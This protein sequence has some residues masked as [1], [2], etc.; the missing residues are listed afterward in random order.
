M[1]PDPSVAWLGQL[2]CVAR[3]IGAMVAPVATDAE[4]ELR[5]R[6]ARG[7][8][9]VNDENG[10]RYLSAVARMVGVDRT[11]VTRWRDGSTT[12][13]VDHCRSLARRYPDHFDE[14]RLVELHAL[15]AVAA[16]PLAS[17]P[18]ESPYD[19]LASLSAGV[20]VLN[21]TVE[22]HLAAAEALLAD[23]GAPSNRVC[24]MASLHLDVRGTDSVSLDP[25][26][27]PET[28]RAVET[29]RE[30]TV[31]RAAEGWRIRNVITA[32]NPTRLAGLQLL[33]DS[34]D[35]ADVEIRAYPLSVPLVLSP[36]IVANREVILA[37]DHRRWERPHAGL[38]IRSKPVVDWAIAYFEQLF[39]DAPHVLRTVHGADPEGF[40]ALRAEV[41]A[42]STM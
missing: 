5:Q 23:P 29:F 34:V 35:G 41:A 7:I 40:A 12:A 4:T 32:G 8:R 24:Q 36:L 14:A 28:V 22:V 18:L 31:R 39:H 38:R 26:M 42:R 17:I 33:V 10:G 15:T 9:A 21:S 11:T 27:D 25:Q 37:Y 3:N 1:R 13:S 30:A 19:A 6:V 20:E 2:C 16:N